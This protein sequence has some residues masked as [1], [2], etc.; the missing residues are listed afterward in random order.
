MCAGTTELHR[1]RAAAR[2][3]WARNAKLGEEVGKVNGVQTES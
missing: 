2:S 3:G 1:V